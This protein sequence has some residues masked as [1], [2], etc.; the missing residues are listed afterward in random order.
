MG[1]LHP[2]MQHL[3]KSDLSQLHLPSLYLL[4][5][6]DHLSKNGD[7]EK[8][9]KQK[10]N[11]K[12]HPT[13]SISNVPLGFFPTIHRSNQPNHPAAPQSP[14]TQCSQSVAPRWAPK[15]GGHP[16]T[17]QV[18]LMET[19]DPIMMVYYMISVYIYIHMYTCI[20][21]ERLDVYVYIYI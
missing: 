2:R 21:R 6:K 7:F 20:E 9:K 5:Y 13:R 15:K 10:K 1:Y 14:Q 16:G 18:C 8:T 12:N 4:S 17:N 19:G 11:M 3:V